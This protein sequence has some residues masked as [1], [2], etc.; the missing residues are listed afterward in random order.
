MIY[1]DRFSLLIGNL[2]NLLIS[3][4]RSKN[5]VINIAIEDLIRGGGKRLR[6]ILML[7][8]GKFGDFNEQKM[9]ELAAGLELLHMATLV[10]DDIIDEAKLRRGEKTAQAK[11]GP[12]I[13][14]FVGDYLLT[15]SYLMFSR[16]LSRHSLNRLNKIVKLI[17]EGE[18]NQYQEKYNYNLTVIDYLKRI[19]K[20]TALL[21]GTSTYIGAYES[22]VRKKEL[23]HLY[24]FGLELGM[25]FQVQDDLLDFI[26][27][28]D[29]TGKKVGQDLKAGIYTLPLIYL[30]DSAHAQKIKKMLSKGTLSEDEVELISDLTCQE[31]CLE[32]SRKLEQ[33]FLDKA[34]THLDSLPDIKIKDDLRYIIDWQLK[35]ES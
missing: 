31:G 5:P 7:L 26:G 14:V 18:I 2:N 21:F 1:L 3:H 17:C 8:A 29:K 20:K 33:Q 27:S 6:P 23:Y 19:R 22:G 25:A 15:R 28:E 34:M 11:F 12:N 10:H 9:L 32:K 35:R 4:C 16:Y 24:K 13:A 30:L